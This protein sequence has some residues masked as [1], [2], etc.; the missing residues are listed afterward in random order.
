MVDDLVTQP[1]TD[2]Y[3]MFTSRSE[4]RLLLR[5]DNADQRLTELG[6][7]IGLVS[8]ERWDKYQAK[9]DELEHIGEYLK[10]EALTVADN[11]K[12]EFFENWRA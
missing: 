12:L 9:R 6:R 5:E 1:T 10:G 8:D 3:R 11:D 2:P 4:Y 7:N